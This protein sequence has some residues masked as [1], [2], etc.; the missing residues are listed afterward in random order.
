MSITERLQ[1]IKADKAAANLKAG[2]DFLKAN[3]EKAG[4][5]ELPSGLQYEIIKEGEGAK[6]CRYQYGYMPL[7]RYND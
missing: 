5:V 2:E 7:S 6:T 4:V 3:K 1:Q